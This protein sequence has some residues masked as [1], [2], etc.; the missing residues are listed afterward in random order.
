MQMAR[1]EVKEAMK[2]T[3][4]ER[5]DFPFENRIHVQ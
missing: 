2:E 1:Q 5:G 3:R 4:S